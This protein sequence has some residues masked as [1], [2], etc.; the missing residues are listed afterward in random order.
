MALFAAS[1]ALLCLSVGWPAAAGVTVHECD[2]LAASAIDY[3]RTAPPV[4]GVAMDFREAEKVCWE[5][6]EQYPDQPRYQFQLGSVLLLNGDVENGQWLMRQSAESG[7]HAAAF[8]MGQIYRRGLFG[9]KKPEKAFEWFFKA[10]QGGHPDAQYL[11]GHMYNRGKGVK[12]DINKAVHWFSRAV[13]QGNLAAMTALGGMYVA[14]D[15]VEQDIDYGVA[16]LQRAV[17]RGEQWAQFLLGK[18]YLDELFVPPNPN[19]A[20]EL[21]TLSAHQNNPFSMVELGKIYHEGKHR[22]K[23]E[24]K[25]ET[26]FC[27]A[28]KVG[29][30]MFESEYG[31]SLKCD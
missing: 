11:V 23:N 5:A 18:L 1:L 12:K 26:F 6:V 25:A 21:F 19:R 28:G 10:A 8:Y 4:D 2:R 14:G 7:Y 30:V 22:Q 13:E 15:G 17:N 3:Q 29:K 27:E 16:M 31:I 20:I 24:K 9:V